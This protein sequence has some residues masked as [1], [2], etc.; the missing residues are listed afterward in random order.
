MFAPGTRSHPPACDN[1][2]R[3]SADS[4]GIG[5]RAGARLPKQY[6][7]DRSADVVNPYAGR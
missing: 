1:L 5:I 6:A 7:V 4:S 2:K 3:E